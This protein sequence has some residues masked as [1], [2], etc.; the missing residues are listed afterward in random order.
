MSD[1]TNNKK[2]DKT[3]IPT[4]KESKPKSKKSFLQ[5][6]PKIILYIAGSFIL[7]LVLIFVFI[8]TP[9]FNKI[10]LN[11]SLGQV[12]ES[13]KDKQSEITAES[14]DG[15]ILTGV[16]LNNGALTVQKD[17]LM[18]FG[19]LDVRYD[20]WGLLRKEIAIEHI[21]LNEPEINLVQVK[22]LGDSILWNFKYL[23]GT[24]EEEVDTSTTPFDWGIIVEDLKIHN[25]TIRVVDSNLVNTSV[26]KYPFSQMHELN[27][28]AL[29]ISNLEVDLAARYFL[30]SKIL[31]LKKVA[32][33][34]NSPFNLKKFS[35][36]AEINVADTIS[37][38]KNLEF[39]TDRT[40]LLI[41]EVYMNHFNP[42]DTVVYERFKDNDVRL[43]LF[44][45]KFDIKDLT[46]FI[47]EI[48]FLDS[49]VAL[50]L[51]ADGK[52]G[53]LNLRKLVL[54]TADSYYNFQGKV[55][56]LH[57][58]L[59]LYFDVT[60]NDMV[61]DPKDTKNILP[62]LPIPDYSHVGKIFANIRYVGEPLDFNSDFDIRT[63]Y[64]NTN[65]SVYL[66]LN[67][68]VYQYKGNVET[69]GLNI[70]AILKDKELQSNLNLRAE[71]NGSGFDVNTMSAR[72]N[73]QI[74]GSRILDQNIIQSSGVV[75]IAGGNATADLSIKMPTLSSSVKGRI[76]IN[77]TANAEYVLVGTANGLDISQF[78][79][80]SEDKSNINATFNINGRGTDLDNISGTF[81]MNV[82]RSYYASYNIPPTPV[83]IEIRN[84][85]RNGSVKVI[86]DFFDF[87]ARGSFN[88]GEIAD[89][90]QYNIDKVVNEVDRQLNTD[91]LMFASSPG[92]ASNTLEPEK[93]FSHFDFEY[94]FVTKNME[95]LTKVFDTSGFKFNGN[96]SGRLSNSNDDFSSYTKFNIRDFIYRD[97]LYILNNV[98]GLIDYKND[99]NK[100]TSVGVSALYPITAKVL[101]N[102]QRIKFGQ[103]NFDSV[104]V[105]VN[106][107]NAMQT[108][109]VK[110]RQDTAFVV[111]VKGSTNLAK[112]VIGVKLDSLFL[113][114]N[115]FILNNDGQLVFKY[116]MNPDEQSIT[117]DRFNIKNELMKLNAKGK[118]SMAGES[119]LNLDA[120]GIKVA[121]ILELLYPPD[122]SLDKTAESK[123]KTPV[124]GNIRR[125]SLV[126]KGDY[127][128]PE[129]K[130]EMNS[131]LL[132][133]ENSKIGRIDAFVDYKNSVLVTDVLVSNASGN[134]KLRLTGDIPFDNPMD[135]VDTTG[136]EIAN[137]PV[138]FKL[139]AENFQLNFFS[140]LIPNF[141]DLRGFL[142]GEITTTGTASAPV[143]AGNMD[144]LKGRFL[145][146]LTGLYHRFETKLKTENSNLVIENF[147]IYNEED[148]IRHINAWGTVNF[149]GLK[150]NNIDISTSGDIEVLNSS[151]E[152]N[153]LG[154]YGDLIVGVGTPPVTLKGNLEKM[155]LAGQFVIKNANVNIATMPG[156][157][158]DPATDNF[159]YR[160]IS[161][162]TKHIDTVIYISPEK[163]N[164]VDPFMRT[165]AVLT[166]PKASV[167]NLVYDLN[168]RT[169]K[170]AYVSAVFNQ[171]TGEEL[172]GEFNVNLDITNEN[173]KEMNIYGDVNIVGDSYYRFYRN[174]KVGQ[175]KIT[176][177]G[178]ADDPYLDI[179]AVYQSRAGGTNTFGPQNAPDEL[180]TS[181]EGVLIIL[182]IKGKKSQPELTLKIF[183]GN[184]EVTG[185]DGQ[186]EAISY[187][188]F[189]VSR[190]ELTAQQRN[191]LARNVGA[192]VGSSFL[193]SVVG[194]V[195]REIAPFIVSAEVN[196]DPSGNVY[197]GTDVRVTSEFGDATVR[198]G[199]KILSGINNTEVS[200]QYP[201]NRLFNI[202]V[203]NNLILEL[204]R[205][206]D[207]ASLSGERQLLYGL[208]LSYK[209][210]Y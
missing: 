21:V 122:T 28:S 9:W 121:E 136:A 39:I 185:T 158:Y 37:H 5:R 151:A 108:F 3:N 153:E 109:Q 203:S 97:S 197:S 165:Y 174:F 40:N 160:L 196:Y 192:N 150:I 156:G 209:I 48:N 155:T 139:L 170:N 114:Y 194:N 67:T 128:N 159:V 207:D 51:K 104:N 189:G 98:N 210:T 76:N 146:G 23:F 182:D 154:L 92:S 117:F 134:G 137:I 72:V 171:L 71:V 124:S 188:L 144:I 73:Y 26:S 93:N 91:T 202:N 87:N 22:G 133:Y 161:D 176:F 152:D 162:S 138:N 31:N 45:E 195:M 25:G 35:A 62:G 83:D 166:E 88:L 142:N 19:Y 60:A 119:D 32:F 55:K 107:E 77:N 56:N 106:L 47:P 126:Y 143:L 49:T 140:K 42:F 74:T 12:N 208:K 80:N 43:E 168:I 89:V 132:R 86:T 180:Q 29:K 205:E 99:Y 112:E 103:N 33:N 95:A 183:E 27:T 148:N 198:I 177:N 38:I 200:V 131:G 10:A 175:S 111:N 147:R 41:K 75:G 66:N 6:L 52:Y 116:N 59:K 53:D 204:S 172:F 199:G 164:Q 100:Y 57:D 68:P 130:L 34:T 96:I 90:I 118:F 184:S 191:T 14:I 120:T 54:K 17:T 16:R 69:R 24:K 129:V 178:P 113:K 82:D 94:D 123:Y 36:D 157:G 145:F 13:W 78:T 110:G 167:T 163:I 46:F 193:S 102:G 50:D 181:N 64:G 179:H 7:L 105:N 125:L 2:E 206:I 18:K 173:S 85:N 58:P 201:L 141:A 4:G 127:T 20:V 81:K 135:G 30:N 63:A 149:E 11:Y 61:I 79:K 44:T 169:T 84:N 187:L 115:K 186:S 65:G 15:N 1:Q 190:N 101:I 70:G 8:Q